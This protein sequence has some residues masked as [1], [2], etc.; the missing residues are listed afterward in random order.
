MRCCNESR[1]VAI[2][3]QELVSIG[4]KSAKKLTLEAAGQPGLR[5]RFDISDNLRY[6]L[7]LK[8]G[9]PKKL[10]VSKL[11]LKVYGLNRGSHVSSI[12]RR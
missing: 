4:D 6:V 8:A 3:C 10:S 5:G 1:P 9:K 2:S 11:P 12:A 7:N